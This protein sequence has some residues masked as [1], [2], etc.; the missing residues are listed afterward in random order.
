MTKRKT[1]GII[2]G[3]FVV[4]AA[5]GGFAY[6]SIEQNNKSVTYL[7]GMEAYQNKDYAA[8]REAFES[9]GN[10]KNAPEILKEVDYQ[11]ALLAIEQG[12]EVYAEELLLPIKEYKDAESYL[13]HIT[14]RKVKRAMNEGDYIQAEAYAKEITGYKDVAQLMQEIIYHQAINKVDEMDFEGAKALL[15]TMTDATL[16]QKG[17]NRISYSKYCVPC[18]QDLYSR[19]TEGVKID[20]INGGRYCEVTYNS[21]NSFPVIMIQYTVLTEG[22]EA[23]EQYAAYNN[24]DFFGTCHTIDVNRLD[25]TNQS[26]MAAYLKI[27]PNWNSPSAIELSGPA[28]QKL[29]GY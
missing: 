25:M 28:M 22:G 14:Y 7:A 2:I 18:I 8:A 13:Y 17:M 29:A 24:Y 16:A 6:Y 26:E 10:Y 9:I 11:D 19:Y 21:G 4:I 20:K 27:E 5:I 3:A 1:I 15:N 23:V 12:D